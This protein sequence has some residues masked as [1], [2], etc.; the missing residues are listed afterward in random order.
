MLMKIN[1][2]S[3]G[4][5]HPTNIIFMHVFECQF[6]RYFLRHES[7]YNRN[8]INILNIVKYNFKC[9]FKISLK[10]NISYTLSHIRV[11]S[12]GHFCLVRSNHIC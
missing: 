1:T 7:R 3:K 4:D 9:Y 6:S 8:S 11:T 5:H 10:N 2:L 12:G